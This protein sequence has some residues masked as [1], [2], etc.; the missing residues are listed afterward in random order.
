[1]PFAD[2]LCAFRISLEQ[3]AQHEKR[4]LKKQKTKE[5]IALGPASMEPTAKRPR[6]RSFQAVKLPALSA[7]RELSDSVCD[8]GP[9]PVVV[10]CYAAA[11][12]TPLTE[13]VIIY[14]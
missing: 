10:H 5:R 6:G 13:G 7:P 12:D 3:L 8:A 11:P 9:D 1:M 4:F 2:H 14:G